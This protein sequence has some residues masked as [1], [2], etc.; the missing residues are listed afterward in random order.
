MTTAIGWIDD[1]PVPRE[2]L[3]RRIADLRNGP[4]SSALPVPGS[5]ED[6]QLA[7]WLTQVILTEALCEST[8]TT[9]GLSP[10]QPDPSTP[11]RPHP[12]T[13]PRP[14][15]DR[16]SP[17]ETTA[18]KALPDRPA[19]A[20]TALSS[21][22]P[23]PAPLDRPTPDHAPLEPSA[24]DQTDV[25]PEVLDRV[26][27]VEL[28]SINAAAY[29]GSPWVRAVF[30]HVTAAVTVPPEWRRP[31]S[32]ER[33][34]RH[35]VRHRLFTDPELA[36]EATEADLERL[37]P[38]ELDSLPGT[39]AEALRSHPYDT[40]VGPVEDALG[41]HVAVATPEPDPQQTTTTAS[42]LTPTPGAYQP[43]PA[44]DPRTYA[45]MPTPTVQQ[46]PPT[47]PR[48][49]PPESAGRQAPDHRPHADETHDP[50][51]VAAARR[52]AFARWL[53]DMR[54][55]KVRLVPGLEHPGDPRQPDN[56]HK[57]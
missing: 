44:P 30:Q 42:R 39:I 32:P 45:P 35:L 3:D 29:N 23:N 36:R 5:S 38:V 9:L 43:A 26:A 20:P 1:R 16:P 53:D 57:H 41:W 17:H 27:A 50:H 13:S 7:R 12:P 6:R 48:T 8:A 49:P 24:L 10:H 15:P 19:P 51:L 47:D 37:G 55:K 54:A 4:L 52:Q 18:G 33:T 21:T 2:L 28:G 56:H 11:A 46:A 40:L 34:P 14:R 31:P 25:R 22:L